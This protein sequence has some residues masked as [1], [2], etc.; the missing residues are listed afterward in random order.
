M[1]ALREKATRHN[2][3]GSG[4]QPKPLD[5]LLTDK[6]HPVSAFGFN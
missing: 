5:F 2:D 1:A 3:H 6:Q 4:L